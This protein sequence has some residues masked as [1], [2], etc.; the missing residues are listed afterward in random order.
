[1]SYLPWGELNTPDADKA[2]LLIKAVPWDMAASAGKGAM[3]APDKLRQ[4]SKV[5]PPATEAFIIEDFSVCDLGDFDPHLNWEQYWSEIRSGAAEMLKTGKFC[6]FLGGDHSITI[7][8]EEAF[9]D[10][11]QGKKVGIIHFDSHSDILIDYYGHKWSHACTQRRALE[12][13]AMTDRGLTLVG[14]RSWEAEELDFLAKHPDIKVIRAEEIYEMGI[15]KL[16]DALL[17]RY[18]GF[19]AVYF[20]IDI[21]FLDPSCAPGTGTPESGGPSTRELMQLV[22]AIIKNLPVKAMDIVEVSPPRDSSDITSWAALKIM[23]E[24]FGQLSLKKKNK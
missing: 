1:M 2:D 17:E 12:H 23:Y 19:D 11:H 18:K 21:D 15:K 10:V 6:F 24:V 5:L 13:P 3:E 16:I 20:T 8:T 22:K 9:L 7:P 14:I 4:L